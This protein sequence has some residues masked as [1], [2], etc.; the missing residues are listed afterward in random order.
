MKKFGMLKLKEIQQE[1]NMSYAEMREVIGGGNTTKPY[2]SFWC[3]CEDGSASWICVGE[4]RE[5]CV[6]PSF[7]QSYAYECTPNKPIE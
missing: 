6:R 5:D 7:C 2:I 1:A 3:T 4:S